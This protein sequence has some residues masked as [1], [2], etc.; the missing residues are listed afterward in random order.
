M[1]YASLMVHVDIERSSEKR[2]RLAAGLARRFGAVLIGISGWAPRPAMVAP[3][4]IVDPATIEQEFETM[5]ARLHERE[6]GFH[7]QTGQVENVEWRS[8]LDFPADLILNECRAADLIVLGRDQAPGDF[9]FAVDPGRIVLQAGRPVL[10]VPDD[11]ESL[12]ARRAVI[13]W[14]DTRE[15][16]R[17]LRDALP[18]L[19]DAEEI[20]LV[21][22][23]EQGS[24]DEARRRLDDVASYLGRHRLTVGAKAM[25]HAKGPAGTE[26][27][28]FAENENADLIVAGGYG[29]A[30]LR[31]WVF[32]G[33]T[34]ALL[35][36]SPVC[37]LLS[38]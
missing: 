35:S 19:R 14:K 17:A 3:G 37:C 22:V 5:R 27:L 23:C 18:L 36:A 25:L 16:R 26:L 20:L 31:E 15:A 4:V 32:G 33:V 38:H 1:A 28:G 6:R 21:E 29:H 24:E 9:Y 30:R 10:L 11:V 13:A 8:G 7:A 2:I 12:S 34:Q